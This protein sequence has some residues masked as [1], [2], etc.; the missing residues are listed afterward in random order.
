MGEAKQLYI[1]ESSVLNYMILSEFGEYFQM[2]IN[3]IRYSKPHKD[4]I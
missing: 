3:N 1:P 2:V 4:P